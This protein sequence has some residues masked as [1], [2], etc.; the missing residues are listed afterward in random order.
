MGANI[1]SSMGHS[2]TSVEA[3]GGYSCCTNLLYITQG[4]RGTLTPGSTR[5]IA[6]ETYSPKG[7]VAQWAYLAKQA[8]Q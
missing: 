3:Q 2:A 8:I 1:P 4:S 6:S 5:E 7:A